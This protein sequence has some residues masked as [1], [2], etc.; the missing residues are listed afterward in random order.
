MTGLAL[1]VHVILAGVAIAATLGCAQAFLVQAP[2]LDAARAAQCGAGRAAGRTRYALAPLLVGAVTGQTRSATGAIQGEQS[3]AAC[4]ALILRR[5]I[6][7]LASRMARRAIVVLS[8]VCVCGTCGV[9]FVLVH[10]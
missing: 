1:A 9:T 5:A 3:G 10:H 6:A 7:G 2:S 8:F 4:D